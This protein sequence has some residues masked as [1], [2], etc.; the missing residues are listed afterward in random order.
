[1]GI[2]SGS[3]GPA[4]TCGSSFSGA[5]SVLTVTGTGTAAAAA[6]V[7]PNSVGFIDSMATT[8]SLDTVKDGADAGAGS[9]ALGVLKTSSSMNSNLGSITPTSAAS[10]PNNLSTSTGKRSLWSESG[11][12]TKRT[13]WEGCLGIDA[14]DVDDVPDYPVEGAK[15]GGSDK[16]NAVARGG[17]V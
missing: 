11:V 13:R 3:P 12:G 15:S 1:M 6:N 8:K 10:E 9:P 7:D 5:G 14:M 2:W 17:V 16:E 4:S